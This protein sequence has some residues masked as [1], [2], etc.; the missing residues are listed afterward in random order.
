MHQIVLN[1]GSNM[2]ASRQCETPLC[3]SR[4]MHLQI[5]K[6]KFEEECENLSRT[7]INIMQQRSVRGK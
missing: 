7:E 4:K 5:E 6:S 3:E 1:N 2:V